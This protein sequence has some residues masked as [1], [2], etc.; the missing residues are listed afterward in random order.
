[1]TRVT[2]Q[3]VEA[4]VSNRTADRN[5]REFLNSS[6]TDT[7]LGPS[8]I[9]TNLGTGCGNPDHN[10]CKPVLFLLAWSPNRTRIFFHILGLQP[11]AMAFKLPQ[12]LVG[13]VSQSGA[14]DDAAG[15]SGL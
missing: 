3:R 9:V 7:I 1:V 10:V 11:C 4:E 8:V 5:F 6:Q 13:G 12:V 15:R 2:P 14:Q